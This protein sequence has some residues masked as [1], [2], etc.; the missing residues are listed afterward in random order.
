MIQANHVDVIVIGGGPAGST[1]AAGLLT[2][3]STSASGSGSNVNL[4]TTAGGIELGSA[5]A[6]NSVTLRAGSGDINVDNIVATAGSIAIE[7]TTGEGVWDLALDWYTAIVD[8]GRD[9]AVD[10]A[11]TYLPRV[12]DPFTEYWYG[13]DPYANIHGWL[14]RNGPPVQAWDLPDGQIRAGIPE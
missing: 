2:V 4:T 1:T 11:L 13:V 8:P 10:P 7:A 9:P 6:A 12:Q 14:Q 3:G 5:A